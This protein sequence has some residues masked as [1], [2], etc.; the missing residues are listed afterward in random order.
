MLYEIDFAVDDVNAM[1]A[2]LAANKVKLIGDKKIL[3]R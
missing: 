2:Y 3:F 1:R